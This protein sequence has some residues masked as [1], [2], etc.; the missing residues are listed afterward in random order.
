MEHL[1]LTIFS[2]F[3]QA[4][5]G[6]MVFVAIAKFID[7]ENTYK[8]AIYTAAGLGIIGVLASFLHLGRPLKAVNALMHPG[9]SWLSREIWLTSAFV[10]LVVLVALLMK[11]RPQSEGATKGLIIA[12]AL[13][14][15]ADVYAMGAVYVFASVPVW[16]HP[17]VFMEFYAATI[18]IGAVLFIALSGE[19]SKS[20]KK[21]AGICVAVSITALIVMMFPYYIRIGASNSLAAQESLSLLSGM[22]FVTVVKWG[23]ILIGAGWFISSVMGEP[24]LSKGILS[25]AAMLVTGQVVG[26]YLFYAMMVVT[27]VGLN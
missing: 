27:R 20:L 24:K 5:V 14:G 10:G 13:V 11:F 12:A 2:T 19:Q 8:K 22:S 7:K 15:L 1:T 18:S 3:V 4:T 17:A 25:A 16:N 6:I 23:F 26:R 21:L 9:S